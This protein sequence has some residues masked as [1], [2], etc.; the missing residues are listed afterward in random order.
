MGSSLTK[1]S[2]R[3]TSPVEPKQT[4]DNADCIICWDDMLQ[5][6]LTVLC[7]GHRYHAT[8][9]R[10]W[11]E[12]NSSCPLCRR[13]DPS[14]PETIRFKIINDNLHQIYQSAMDDLVMFGHTPFISEAQQLYRSAHAARARRRRYPELPLDLPYSIAITENVRITNE[15]EETLIRA[16]SHQSNE[17]HRLQPLL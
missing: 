3:A 8:C 13:Y 4:F 16:S 17:W 10:P 12:L 11:M 2:S 9:I 6:E 5:G 15:I 14:F 7:C 1:E